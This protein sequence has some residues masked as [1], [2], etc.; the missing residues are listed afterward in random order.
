MA[1]RPNNKAGENVFMAWSSQRQFDVDGAQPVQS[2]YDEVKLYNFSNPGFS[3]QTGHFTQVVWKNSSKL[4]CGKAKAADSKV[5][6]VCN[7]DPPGNFQG[8]FPQNVEPAR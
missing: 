8:R 5:F 2:W 3:M 6:V 1:H 7:Y 4:G